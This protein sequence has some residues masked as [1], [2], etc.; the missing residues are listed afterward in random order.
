MAKRSP[1]MG[2]PTSAKRGG[3]LAH[4]R[5]A[6][7]A[8]LRLGPDPDNPV[9]RKPLIHSASFV[10]H[11]VRGR[12]SRGGVRPARWQ[13]QQGIAAPERLE[14]QPHSQQGSTAIKVVRFF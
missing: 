7:F 1:E 4:V 14:P 6:V 2:R 13:Q 8:L 10:G 5:N 3:N 12:G 9:F 11:E